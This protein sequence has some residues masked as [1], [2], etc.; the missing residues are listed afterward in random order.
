M[1]KLCS[2][3]G[4]SEVESGRGLCLAPR[5]PKLQ[6]RSIPSL[7]GQCTTT[8]FGPTCGISSNS[9]LTVTGILSDGTQGRPASLVGVR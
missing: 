4:S 5:W 8:A 2:G 7:P 6:Y 1:I 3:P 9:S